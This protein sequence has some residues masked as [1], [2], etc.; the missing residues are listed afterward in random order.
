MDT[1]GYGP[2]VHNLSGPPNTSSCP[3]L[4]SSWLSLPD[5]QAAYPGSK[6]GA[7][8]ASETPQG[9]LSNWYGYT[10]KAFSGAAYG[11]CRARE[12]KDMEHS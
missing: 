4:L 3:A 6:D 5:L 11:L 2:W 12:L 7:E 1:E 9:N 10:T 8:Q